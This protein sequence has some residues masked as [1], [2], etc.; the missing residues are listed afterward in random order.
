VALAAFL[1]AIYVMNLT[2]PPPPDLQSFAAVG[3]AAWILPLWAWWADRHREPL[4]AG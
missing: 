1:A 4:G 2:S 3:L